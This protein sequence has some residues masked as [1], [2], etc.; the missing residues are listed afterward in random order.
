MLKRII[1]ASLI[2]ICSTSLVGCTLSHQPPTCDQLKSQ[3]LYYTTN[4]NLEASWNTNGQK[5]A[6]QQKMTAMNCV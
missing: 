5:E 4:P 1:Q 3:W 6:L 2:A